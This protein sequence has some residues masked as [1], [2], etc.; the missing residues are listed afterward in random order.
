MPGSD[1]A[2]N[3]CTV[4]TSKAGGDGTLRVSGIRAKLAREE[5]LLGHVTPYLVR[6]VKQPHDDCC[7]AVPAEQACRTK[8]CTAAGSCLPVEAQ[9]E[10]SLRPS[11]GGERVLQRP[12]RPA[13]GAALVDVLTVRSCY[14]EGRRA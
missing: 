12:E 6:G 3:P 4:G 13:T 2:V 5:D 8:D 1:A 9:M 7:S 11:A 10:P 14:H